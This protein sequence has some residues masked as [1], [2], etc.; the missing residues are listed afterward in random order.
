[1]PVQSMRVGEGAVSEV[2]G[3]GGVAGA[4]KGPG[5]AEVRPERNQ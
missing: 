5:E 4:G 2:R 3:R 1:M